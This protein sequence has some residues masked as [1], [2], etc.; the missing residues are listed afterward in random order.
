MQQSARKEENGA[1][2][3]Q[4][5]DSLSCKSALLLSVVCCIALIHVELRIQEHYRL[6]S[7][8]VTYCGQMEKLIL[9]KIQQN[10]K[11]DLGLS[12]DPGP[13]GPRGPPGE[14]GTKGEPGQSISAPTLLQR[15]VETTVNESQ[16]AILK[17]TADG[18]PTPLVTWSKM[19]SSLPAGRHVE[20]SSGA[21][22]ATN[23]RR[24]ETMVF[25][26]AALKTCWDASTRLRNLQFNVS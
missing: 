26:A 14:K 10:N 5:V 3:R 9:Q 17:C 16:T 1:I 2:R 8:S 23:V 18:N 13:V 19:N 11:R 24:G 21:L 20:G 15:P 4:T 22:I 6:I 7:S 25:T 12:G